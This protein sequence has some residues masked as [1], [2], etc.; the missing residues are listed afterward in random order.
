MNARQEN[1]V[2]IPSDSRVALTVLRA[3]KIT[4]Q[5]VQQ[6]QKALNNISTQHSV[7]LFWGTWKQK[8]AMGSQRWELFTSLVDQNQ[9]CWSADR[10]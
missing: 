1:Y 5:L 6:C 3:A 4:S 8:L 9:P 10:I 7:G 2:S